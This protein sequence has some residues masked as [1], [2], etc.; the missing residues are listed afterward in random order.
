MSNDCFRPGQPWLDTNGAPIN[1]HGGGILFHEGRY[2]WHGQHMVAEPN[3]NRARVGVHCYSSTDLLNW[4][5]EGIALAVSDDPTSEI[6]RGC[7][8]ERPKVVYS[9]R[10]GQFVM[11]FH[12]EWASEA[13]HYT[14]ARS[15]V[16]VADRPTGPFRFVRS[17]RPHAGLWPVNVRPD[18]QNPANIAAARAHPADFNGGENSGVPTVNTLGRDW[19][20]GQQARDMTLFVDEDGTGY[21]VH[22]SEFNSTL[23]IGALTPDYEHHSESYARAFE[24]RWMEA[25]ALFRSGS[26]YF[27]LA[28]GCT[29]WA[30][31]AAR[32]G[33]AAH[34][35]GPWTELGN[36][37]RGVNPHNGIG[38]ELTWGMQ[39]SFIFR[40]VEQPSRLIAMFDLWTPENASSALHAWL[41][42][43]MQ[44]DGY[45]IP[46]R[47]EWR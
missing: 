12:L 18:Q 25:P 1:A 36:P 39:S 43:E 37:C 19:A 42:I 44:G 10:T 30:P 27:L 46:W 13:D 38:P 9:R 16:A 28:S 35:F 2:Y 3:G 21:H 6:T 11:W 31:N 24:H 33:R 14:T 29:G 15:A 7:V 20:N 40:P 47:D 17:M 22:T 45:V 23:H 41:P 34:P 4:K 8:L 32:S 5:D 26:Q